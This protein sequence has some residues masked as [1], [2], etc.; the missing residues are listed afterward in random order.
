[1]VV[2]TTEDTHIF[3]GSSCSQHARRLQWPAVGLIQ[4]GQGCEFRWKSFSPGGI[5]SVLT[6]QSYQVARK[7]FADVLLSHRW[8]K[9]CVYPLFLDPYV[10][11]TGEH[12]CVSQGL[13]TITPARTAPQLQDMSPGCLHKLVVIT[14]LLSL[15]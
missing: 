7:Y 3:L 5:N 11:A 12:H 1:M 14:P 13:K 8:S 15:V 2:V 4:W 10:L 9:P 6:E